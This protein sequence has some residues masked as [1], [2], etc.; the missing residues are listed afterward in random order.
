MAHS[1]ETEKQFYWDKWNANRDPDAG[2]K[3]LALY[4]PLV[5]YHV[6]RIV[7]GLP[8]GI[9]I[10]ELKS[11]G[12]IGLYDALNRFDSGRDLKFDTYASFRVRGAILDGLRKEDWI[13][14]S[15]REKA[16]K[17]DTAVDKLQ[18]QFL[19]PV[20]AKEVAEETGLKE[21]EVLAVQS[22]SFFANVLSIDDDHRRGEEDQIDYT[23]ED[24]KTATP[25]KELIKEETV[26]DLA[27]VIETLNEREQLVISL[28][29][30]EELTLTEIGKVLGVSTSRISQIHSRALFRLKQA[31][32]QTGGEMTGLLGDTEF[33]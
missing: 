30:Y 27:K 28:F 24:K 15:L 4:M 3:L 6:Q 16:K 7:V 21:E 32:L 14:R 29:Y 20:T 2:E 9:D 25:E 23:I 13:P 1:E 33:T 22:E 8:K 31:L 19:R 26:R 10:E 5:H 12:M 18:Q 11:L 17:V